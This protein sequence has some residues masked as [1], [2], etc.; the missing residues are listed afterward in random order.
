[1]RLPNDDYRNYR[2]HGQRPMIARP[3]R[4]RRKPPQ[5]WRPK[6]FILLVP[7]AILLGAYVITHIEPAFS[8]REVMDFAHIPRRNYERFS[9]L[10]CLALVIVGIVAIARVLRDDKKG[11]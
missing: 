4:K 7:A 5:R 6:W 8:W 11:K 10:A 1:M 9:G 2:F 3:R